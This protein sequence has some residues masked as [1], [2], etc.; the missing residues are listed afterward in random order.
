MLHPSPV[1]C[2]VKDQ[3]SALFEL[4]AKQLEYNQ[5]IEFTAV[6]IIKGNHHVRGIA[7]DF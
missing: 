4:I 2:A 3:K 6:V 7:A 5:S 1:M